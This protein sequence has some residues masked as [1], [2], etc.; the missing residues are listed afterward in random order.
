MGHGAKFYF[1]QDS[2]SFFG[3]GQRA[4]T[5]CTLIFKKVAAKI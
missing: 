4:Q 1:G 3:Q 5:Q 2:Q